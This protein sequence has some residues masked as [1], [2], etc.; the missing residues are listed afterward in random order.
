[1]RITIL[2]AAL[3]SAV[4]LPFIAQA[5][6]T[7]EVRL[8]RLSEEVGRQA[9]TIR[10]QQKMIDELKVQQ[11]NTGQAAPADSSAK[12]SGLFGGSLMNNPYISVILDAK[13][14]ISNQKSGE[15]A[16][17]G[18]PGYTSEGQG[19][20]NGFNVD[21]AELMI[22]APV[23]PYFNLYTNIP[24]SDG[25]AALEEAY[26]V[27]TAL[28]EGFQLKGG[29]FKSN[30]SRLNGQHPHAWDFADLPTAPVIVTVLA[31]AFFAAL[32][33]KMLGGSGVR[34]WQS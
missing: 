9:E 8:N 2:A 12:I 10:T 6:D 18:V 17:R 34:S 20:K 21:A 26:V 24:V 25:G 33:I 29:R 13:A 7:V 5:E 23:D 30:A 11:E 16:A 14:Y 27:T 19:V 1:M 4:V 31:L 28:P 15:L 32:I 3:M 22:F